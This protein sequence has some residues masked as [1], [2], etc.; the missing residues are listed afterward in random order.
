[1]PD[2]L[3]T[4]EVI[5]TMLESFE[6]FIVVDRPIC[7]NFIQVIIFQGESFAQYFQ[8]YERFAQGVNAGKMMQKLSPFRHQ[9]SA[10]GVSKYPS[11]KLGFLF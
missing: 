9:R 1:M 4:T 7:L 10:A 2:H 6:Q 5:K 3:G 11:T 8:G